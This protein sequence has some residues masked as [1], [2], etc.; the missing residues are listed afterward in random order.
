M[1]LGSVEV[2]TEATLIVAPNNNRIGLILANSGSCTIFIGEDETLTTTD[3][4]PIRQ[5]ER[6]TE[7]SGGTK[8]YSGPIYGI[9]S[10]GKADIRF[11]ER[12]RQ[13]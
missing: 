4:I 10:S 11:W 6:Y 1:P 2:K 8:M 5:D 12:V 13:T 9:V 7:D 3:G